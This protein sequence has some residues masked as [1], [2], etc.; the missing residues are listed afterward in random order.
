MQLIPLTQ[1][2]FAMV[3]DDVAEALRCHSWQAVQ[4]GGRWYGRCRVRLESGMVVYPYMHQSIAGY[5]LN[6]KMVDH[7][8]G[9]GLNNQRYNLRIA[10]SLQNA[11][12]RRSKSRGKVSRPGVHQA[13]CNG[14]WI[15]QIT[16]DGK[17][18]HLGSF[19]TEDEAY[20]R[21]AEAAADARG[22]FFAPHDRP[23]AELPVVLPVVKNS[24]RVYQ[25]ALSAEQVAEVKRIY[26]AGGG[27]MTSIA[28]EFGVSPNCARLAIRDHQYVRPR[29][30]A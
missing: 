1:G 23:S 19:S 15:A 30:E 6:G 10:T 26:F 18:V 20:A 24:R 13:S 29:R 9:N 8:D 28:R 27:T 12:N 11:A 22:E 21:Y 5:A 14:R 4:R 7:E 17:K 3:D 16:V 25:H 2:K